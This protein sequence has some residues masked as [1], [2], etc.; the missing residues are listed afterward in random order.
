MKLGHVGQTGERAGETGVTGVRVIQFSVQT[1]RGFCGQSSFLAMRSMAQISLFCM[2][3]LPVSLPAGKMSC[4][5]SPGI[6]ARSLGFISGNTGF[7]S[8]FS[9]CWKISS[10]VCDLHPVRAV[11]TLV[12]ILTCR[13]GIN[14]QEVF[15]IDDEGPQIST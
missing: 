11:V 14:Q 15:S 4:Q 2:R 13:R 6:T 10:Q 12:L 9:W 8:R 5:S 1:G 7:S 3:D